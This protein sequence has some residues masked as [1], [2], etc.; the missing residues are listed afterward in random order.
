MTNKR[1]DLVANN[2]YVIILSYLGNQQK[3]PFFA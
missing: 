2:I 3:Q 1:R